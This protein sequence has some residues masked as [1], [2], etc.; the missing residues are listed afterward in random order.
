MEGY[1]KTYCIIYTVYYGECAS[2]NLLP[3]NASQNDAIFA[4]SQF[5]RLQD[6][7]TMLKLLKDTI[8]CS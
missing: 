7:L 6:H 1:G 4:Q 2:R 8:T 5:T 3:D